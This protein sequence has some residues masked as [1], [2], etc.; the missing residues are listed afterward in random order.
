MSNPSGDGGSDDH[1]SGDSLHEEIPLVGRVVA[2]PR[3][4]HE[5]GQRCRATALLRVGHGLTGSQRILE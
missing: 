2:W 5:Q 3:V 4:P 1:G